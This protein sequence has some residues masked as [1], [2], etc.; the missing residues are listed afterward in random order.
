MNKIIFSL[1]VCM[2]LFTGC[3]KVGVRP[4]IT[5]SKDNLSL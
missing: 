3:E 2:I 5:I 1:F 4:V